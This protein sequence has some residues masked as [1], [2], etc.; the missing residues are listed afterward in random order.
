MKKKLLL[1][2][3]AVVLS[4]SGCLKYDSINDYSNIE[5]I[6]IIPNAS[7]P[8]KSAFSS[9]A[10]VTPTYSQNSGD[11]VVQLYARVSW[12]N[13]LSKDLTVKFIK[14]QGAI[15]EYNAK[16]NRSHVMMPDS[17]LSIPSMQ[18]TIPAGQR[19]A[20]IPITIKPA[21]V[22]KKTSNTS[23]YMLS[24]SISDAEGKKIASNYKTILLPFKVGS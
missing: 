3:M 19:E 12:E 1:I 21:L 9:S 2:I 4:S 5:P 11:R 17:G 23:Y 10:S 14:D 20:Y 22:A 15:D 8:R 24:F 7:W 6:V 13:T 16:F 18:V